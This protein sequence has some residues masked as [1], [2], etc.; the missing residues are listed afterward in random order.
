[1][2]RAQDIID[3]PAQ[4][5]P[6]KAYDPIKRLIDLAVSG[7]GLI[8]TAP[9]LLLVTGLIKLTSRGPALYRARRAGVG[10][11]PFDVLKFRTMVEGAD[12]QG[13]ITAGADSRITAVGRF[14]R[15]TKLDELPQLWNILRGE[16]SLVGPRPESSNIV[17][18]HFTAAYRDV[19]AIRPGLTCSGTLYHYVYQEHLRPPAGMDVEEF[20][21]RRLLDPKIALDL[22][23]VHHRTLLYD[24][25]LLAETAW[26]TALRMLGLEPRWRP[27]ITVSGTGPPE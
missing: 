25:K 27:P 24:L 19:L 4:A 2:P 10:G 11:E 16:M 9:V 12:R 13:T 7:I 8:L 20:Y 6:G 5:P 21:V 17:E 26:V 22:H 15:R 3:R 23:Y 14:L 18:D 1:M